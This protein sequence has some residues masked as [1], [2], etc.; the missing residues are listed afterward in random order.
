[1]VNDVILSNYSLYKKYT[2]W[3][4]SDYKIV[5]MDAVDGKVQGISGY[6][7]N[8]NMVGVFVKNND[9]Y[10]FLDNK[11]HRICIDSFECSNRYT[12]NKMRNFKLIDQGD[13]ICEIIYEPYIDPG[14]IIYDS[15]PEEFDF[16]LFLSNNILQS[17][18][19]LS[20]FII[21]RNK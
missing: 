2:L 7:E 9:V 20:N 5:D 8:K 6:T 3:N 11:E 14:M 17:K 16:L 13:L 19:T 1:M 21:A 15:D 18:E 10:F 12:D 4:G